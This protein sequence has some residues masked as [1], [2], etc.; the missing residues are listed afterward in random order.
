MPPPPQKKIIIQLYD[1]LSRSAF[2]VFGGALRQDTLDLST[3][4]SSRFQVVLLVA[5]F[6][7]Y[8]S[9]VTVFYGTTVTANLAAKSGGRHVETLDDLL[10]PEFSSVRLIGNVSWILRGSPFLHCDRIW[11]RKNG[12]VL[13][14]LKSHS[15]YNR[16][17]DRI[18]FYEGASKFIME[19]EAER[20]VM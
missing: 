15:V 7:L 18:D 9:L 11:T 5:V 19:E 3:R 12:F 16:I 8:N 2:Q 13:Q 4:G 20:K 10:R 14:L 1:F 6:L 17:E